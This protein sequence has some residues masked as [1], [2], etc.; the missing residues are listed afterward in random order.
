MSVWCEII[1]T[2]RVIDETYCLTAASIVIEFG[3]YDLTVRNEFTV[4]P[5]F[6]ILDVIVVTAADVE[7]EVDVPGKN[8][9]NIHDDFI[10]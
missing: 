2:I 9:G 7:N 4:L 1:G 8:P 5:D 3:D 10:G 6:L